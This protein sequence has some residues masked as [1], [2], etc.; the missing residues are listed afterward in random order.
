VHADLTC[1]KNRLL[2]L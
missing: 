1:N 2:S